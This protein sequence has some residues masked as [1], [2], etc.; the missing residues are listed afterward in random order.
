MKD[1][2]TRLVVHY[3]ADKAGELEYFLRHLL[4]GASGSLR[5]F[6]ERPTR[7]GDKAD[8][9]AVLYGLSAFANAIQSLKDAFTTGTGEA[10][11]WA[12]IHGLRHGQFFHDVRN[13]SSHDGNPVLSLWIDG[14][15]WFLYPVVRYH[16]G[17]RIEIPAQ[18]QPVPSLCLDFAEDFC[19]LLM[20]RLAHHLGRDELRG[21]RNTL[22]QFDAVGAAAQLPEEVRRLFATERARVAE[23]LRNSLYDPVQGAIERLTRARSTVVE[24]RRAWDALVNNLAETPTTQ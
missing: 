16:N 1:L 6:R 20:H 9:H 7:E 11:T 10:L 4:A 24:A 17:N 3:I 13:A 18:Q 8:T 14:Q 19:D 5:S 21:D 23:A 2:H 22:E 12:T 15:F